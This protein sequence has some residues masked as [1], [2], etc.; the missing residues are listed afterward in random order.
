[1]QFN[2]ETNRAS[3]LAGIEIH[4]MLREQQDGFVS[5]N[6][7][8]NIPIESGNPAGRHPLRSAQHGK[9]SEN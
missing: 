1:M 3:P 4:K 2:G 9:K 6:F 7:Y 8:F 5:W